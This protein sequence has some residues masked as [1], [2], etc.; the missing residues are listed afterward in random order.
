MAITLAEK[1]QLKIANG[2]TVPDGELIA[3]NI[4]NH[5]EG[6]VLVSGC[7]EEN[8]AKFKLNSDSEGFILKFDNGNIILAKKQVEP[9]PGPEPDPKPTKISILNKEGYDTFEAALEAAVEGDE[10]IINEPVE[11]LEPV[12]LNKAVTI[13]GK[14]DL[15]NSAEP[16]GEVSANV[17]SL[18]IKGA[19]FSF[20]IGAAVTI[21]NITLDGGGF[22]GSGF[23]KISGQSANLK[24]TDVKIQNYSV[25]EDETAA[26]IVAGDNGKIA[27]SGLTIENI[28][29]PDGK[30]MLRLSSVG[31]SIGG[32]NELSIQLVEKTTI[33]KS[34][35]LTNTEKITVYPGTH[36]DG[37]VLVSGCAETDL[38]KFNFVIS[39]P[40][41]VKFKEGNIILAKKE[42][43]PEPDPDPKPTAISID[44]SEDTFDTLDEAIAAAET[45]AKI[46]VNE[47][48]DIKVPLNIE[49][50]LTIAGKEDVASVEKLALNLNGNGAIAVTA[51]ATLSNLKIRQTA[52]ETSGSGEAASL[53]SAISLRGVSICL[54]LDDIDLTNTMTITLSNKGYLKLSGELNVASSITLDVKEAVEGAILVS[55]CAEEDLSKFKLN[56]EDYLLELKEGNIIFAKKKQKP[57]EPD[58][59]P[60]PTAVGIEGSDKTFDTLAEALAAATDGNTIIINENITLSEALVVDKA[61]TITGKKDGETAIICAIAPAFRIS[62]DATLE[63][64]AFDGKGTSGGCL[65]DFGDGSFE[66]MLADVAI[67]DYTFGSDD[68]KLV[69]VPGSCK[70][71]IRDVNVEN[72]NGPANKGMI[73]I[74]AEGSTLDGSNNV[75]LHLNGAH[76][77]SVKDGASLTHTTPIRIHITSHRH[78]SPIVINCIDPKLFTVAGYELKAE[79]GNLVLVDLKSATDGI[80]SD[81]EDEAEYYTLDGVKVAKERLV[82][83]VYIRKRGKKTDKIIITR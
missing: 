15:S 78:G 73:N 9:D 54:T 11:I 63:N 68:R 16:A 34:A 64:L 47:S 19:Y 83:G 67:R 10:I 41:E 21:E 79:G 22:T 36:S 8:L 20:N 76:T 13:R 6:D 81:G 61:V 50:G 74:G 42:K 18:K 3:L 77:I 65:I 56:S 80:S 70:L 72:V 12:V 2:L 30:A 27:L 35:E 53:P 82:S 45:G 44:G 1:G 38:E 69:D 43:E 4:G 60:K 59:E 7:A 33:A 51:S 25:S 46:I 28:T 62:A 52:G 14:E 31:S 5:A 17:P 48:Q 57:E 26:L 66:L 23:I 75:S 49:K 71:H 29:L 58:P 40:F 32:S 39:D 24:L 37:D 55:G